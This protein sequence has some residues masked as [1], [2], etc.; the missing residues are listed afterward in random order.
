MPL[1][2]GAMLG[3]Y[4]ILA[5]I[6]AGGMGEVYKARDTRLNR[7]VAIKTSKQQFSERFEREARAVAAL[8]HPNICHLYD[9]ATSPDGFGYLVMEFVEGE[10][11]KGPLPVEE[12]LRI[13]KQIAEALS[14]AHEKGIVHRDLKPANIKI[15]SE[16]AVKVLDFG[17][18]K[19]ET[20]AEPT[21]Q[22]SPT[23]TMNATQAGV[24]LGTAAYMSPE[25]ARG[26][27][28]DK[29]ADI[30]AF[31]VVVYEL[32]TGESPFVGTT[33]ADTLIAV[34]TK[35]L[36]LDRVP[37][38]LRPL[39]EKCLQKDPAKRLR[40]IGDMDLLLDKSPLPDGRGSFTGSEPRPKGARLGWVAAGVLALAAI[41]LG[42]STYHHQ[43]EEPPRTLRFLVPMPDGGTLGNTMMPQLSPD[44]R[45]IAFVARV[46]GQSQLMVRDLDSLSSR[47]LI[48]GTVRYPFWSP[49]SRSI[50]FWSPGRLQKID[51]AGGPALTLCSA[52]AINGGTWGTEG[53]IVFA[54]AA[55]GALQRVSATGGTPSEATSFDLGTGDRAHVFPWFLPDGRHFLYTAVSI[56]EDKSVIY[57]GDSHSKDVHVKVT[58]VNSNVVYVPSSGMR[59]ASGIQGGGYLLFAREHTLMAQSFDASK[60]TTTG[61]AFPVVDKLDTRNA[62]RRGYFSASENGTLAYT[63]GAQAENVQ[64]TWYDRSGKA[65]GTVGPL[66]DMSWAALSPDGKTVAFD[67]RDPQTNL[68][69]IWLHDLAR[70]T[71]SRF[72]FNSKN[73]RFPVWSPDSGYL[74]FLSDRASGGSVYKKAVTGIGQEEVVDKDELQ[75]RPTSWTPDGRFIIDETNATTPKTRDDLWVAPAAPGARAEKPR[76]YLQTEFVEGEGRISSNGK[77]LAYRSD[78]TKRNEIYIMTFP[79]PG[80]KWQVSTNGGSLPV[81]SRDGKQ[82][83]YIRS[84]KLIAVD[85]KGTG[86]NPEPGV[87]RPLFDVRL[88]TDNPSF[89]IANDGRFLI[90]TLVEQAYAAPITVVVNWA[91]G[92]KK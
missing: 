41:P 75:K 59:T 69:D 10:S 13:A 26:K 89:D 21:S 2:T 33:V 43:T 35:T 51:V 61:D 25:Q 60:L 18:A 28:V 70:G 44:G 63:S 20:D 54:P 64:M 14:V 6:G 12:V 79:N 83:F 36:D 22:N 40:D 86:A 71:D 47:V 90:P 55:G 34:A 72:T 23:I 4:E 53:V 46:D 67:R 11:P 16:G 91:A 65:L 8:N 81:W 87:P 24:I 84:G 78:E 76:P 52:A 57:V 56:D 3:P 42:Y 5:P 66:M 68:Y 82:L 37:A 30:W 58:V 9:V 45:H 77:W 38:T 1:E 74:A 15:T 19:I 50:A 73:N 39:V 92:L 62:P 17:L 32:V 7:T 88:G 85:I 31:G 49:D 29:R 48:T 80:G 27:R